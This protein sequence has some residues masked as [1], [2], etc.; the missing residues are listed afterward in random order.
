[1]EGNKDNYFYSH[2]EVD[3]ITSEE[4]NDHRER[5]KSV[6]QKSD[7]P[8]I[9][10]LEKKPLP[11]LKFANIIN[12]AGNFWS[13]KFFKTKSQVKENRNQI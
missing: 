3:S 4:T 10:I 13:Q 1:L 8:N 12:A 6:S 9:K 7:L 11:Q 5:E 2:K